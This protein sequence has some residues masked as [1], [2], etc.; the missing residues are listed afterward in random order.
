MQMAVSLRSIVA[1]SL[2]PCALVP[3]EARQVASRRLSVHDPL[4]LW[5][6]AACLRADGHEVADDSDAELIV[7]TQLDADTLEA[8]QRGA[9]LLLLARSHDAVPGGLR[10]DRPAR[11]QPRWPDPSRPGAHLTWSGD[12]IGAFSWIMPELAPNLPVRAPLDFAYAEVLPDHVLSG[13]DPEQHADEVS[14][15]MFAGWVHAPAALIWSFPQGKG[16]MTLTTLHV[17]PER[18]PVATVLRSALVA[19]A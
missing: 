7:A 18:G 12:W 5:D 11:I 13:Y 19:S 4:G 3:A 2:L 14:S 10:L 15:G 9:H 16:R 1:A 8:V 6:V 17:A